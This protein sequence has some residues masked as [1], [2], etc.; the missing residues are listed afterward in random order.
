MESHPD[1]PDKSDVSGPEATLIALR[2]GDWLSDL[3][4]QNGRP[5]HEQLAMHAGVSRDTPVAEA[6]GVSA[7]LTTPSAIDAEADNGWP[8]R[9]AGLGR[10]A[11]AEL[12]A[13]VVVA[14]SIIAG[15]NPAQVGVTQNRLVGLL[16]DRHS[17]AEARDIAR[18]LLVWFDLTGVLAD[19]PPAMRWRAPRSL[20]KTDLAQIAA[21]L[22]A[23]PCPDRA[24]VRAL[25]QEVR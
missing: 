4:E 21:L 9:P 14:P 8:C 20:T 17:H 24:T 6:S 15:S 19:V 7:V 5:R 12:L 23:T 3:V 2:S 25:F 13:R 11:L 22:N 1:M 16:T 18:A 10:V